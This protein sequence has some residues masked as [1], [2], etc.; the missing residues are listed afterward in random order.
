M[1]ETAEI[2]SLIRA[3]ADDLKNSLR[4]CTAAKLDTLR[5]ALRI[6]EREGQKTKAM[7]LRRRIKQLE[8]Q[9]G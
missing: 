4:F 5:E 8:K 9:N 1:A 7:H 2:S 3:S 6:V